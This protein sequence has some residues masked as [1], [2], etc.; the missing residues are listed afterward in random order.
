MFSVTVRDA[1]LDAPALRL[2][3]W[4]WTSLHFWLSPPQHV[5]CW[6]AAPLSLEMPL[7]SIHEP[8]LFTTILKY[9]SEVGTSFQISFE[10]PQYGY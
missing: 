3:Y 4:V 10:P 8:L 7:T 6:M 1:G 2:L 9:P 5:H